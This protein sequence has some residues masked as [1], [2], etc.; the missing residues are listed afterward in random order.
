MIAGNTAGYKYKENKWATII[1]LFYFY[2]MQQHF[3]KLK[4][5][6]FCKGQRVVN[7]FLDAHVMVVQTK[8]RT[9]LWTNLKFT[10][11]SCL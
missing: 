7:N 11:F 3:E 2:L 9:K 5:T 4:S 10:F 8:M 6:G 1:L